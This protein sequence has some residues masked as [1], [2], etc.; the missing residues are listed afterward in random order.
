MP[1]KTCGTLLIQVTQKRCW[2][3]TVSCRPARLSLFAPN[4][5]CRFRSDWSNGLT[6]KFAGLEGWLRVYRKG[7]NLYGPRQTTTSR[8][9]KAKRKT[10]TTSREEGLRG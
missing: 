6:T 7:V 4:A 10:A 8:A 5:A 3:D 9:T 2:Q 1:M